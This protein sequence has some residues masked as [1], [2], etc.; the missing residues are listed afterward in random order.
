MLHVW[1]KCIKLTKASC[2][3]KPEFRRRAIPYSVQGSSYGGKEKWDS[4][5]THPGKSEVKGHQPSLIFAHMLREGQRLGGLLL[6][7]K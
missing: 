7:L 4:G 5:G 2:L 6:T 1:S 3:L